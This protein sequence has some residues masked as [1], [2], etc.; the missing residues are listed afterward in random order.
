M[1]IVEW[2]QSTNSRIGV[3]DNQVGESEL[4]TGLM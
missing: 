3:P 4:S 1:D 2:G